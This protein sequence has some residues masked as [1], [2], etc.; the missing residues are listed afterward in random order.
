MTEQGKS[1][2]KPILLIAGITALCLGNP[3]YTA[4]AQETPATDQNTDQAQKE[5]T[6]EQKKALAEYRKKAAEFMKTVHPQTGK[7]PIASVGVTLDVGENYYFLDAKDARKVLEEEW[8]NPPSTDT[9]G[10]IFPKGQDPYFNQYA[11]EISF[12][13]IGYVSDKDAASINYD[14][15]LAK[16]KKAIKAQNPERKRQGYPTL[17]LVGWAEPP[18]YDSTHKRLF[19]G[20]QVRFEGDDFD[21]LNYNLRFLGRKGV[22]QFNFIAENNSLQDIKAAMPEIEK[23]ASF[24]PGRRYEDF[25]K[26]TDKVAAYGVAGLI[27]GG[28][29]A[30]K[31]GLLGLLLILLKKGWIIILA[32]GAAIKGFFSRL[33]GGGRG[34][35][36][37]IG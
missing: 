9:L 29:I 22:L 4:W 8:G 2:K 20:K 10:L 35:D 15:M 25:N 5:L 28:L 27:A 14:K 3:A 18:H 13:D 37:E 33:S 16:M 31:A 1:M 30:K 21:T 24:M 36:D 26:S 19:W 34:G 11:V 6:P 23:M 32:A 12:D 17:E 7:V